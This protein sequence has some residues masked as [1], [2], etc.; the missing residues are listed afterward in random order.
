MST[1]FPTREELLARQKAAW[2]AERAVDEQAF[3]GIVAIAKKYNI[4]VVEIERIKM[5]LQQMGARDSVS[6]AVMLD[7]LSAM[8]KSAKAEDT[9][10]AKVEKPA[11]QEQK[12]ENEGGQEPSASGSASSGDSGEMESELPLPDGTIVTKGDVAARAFKDGGFETAD[13]WNEMSEEEISKRLHDTY[14][15]MCAEVKAAMDENS[16]D[17]KNDE[18]ANQTDGDKDDNKQPE[19]SDDNKSDNGGKDDKTDK[20]VDLSKLTKDKLEAYAK[21]HFGVDIDKRKSKPDLIAEV[22][23]LA[24]GQK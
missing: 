5:G 16:G 24:A 20:K 17:G 23:A 14:D 11:K 9:K 8:E 12:D 3:Q 19:S 15:L 4:D 1:Q 10:Q 2:A 22:E 13:Q 18:T 21:E 6:R 7:I